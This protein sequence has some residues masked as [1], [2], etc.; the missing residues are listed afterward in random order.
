MIPRGQTPERRAYMKA[1]RESHPS[2]DRRAYKAAYDA[3]NRERIAEYRAKNKARLAAI[4]AEWYVANRASVLARVK[5]R[6]QEKRTEILAYQE[7][8][9]AANTAKVKANVR[10]YQAANPDKKIHLANRRRARQ[11]GN[12]G[13][14]TVAE[15]LAKFAALGNVC[16]YCRKP[17]RLTIDHDIPLARGGTDNIENILPACKSCNSKKNT[18][19]SVEFFAHQRSGGVGGDSAGSR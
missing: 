15:R 17:G 18:R 7:R 4:K 10:A 16:V 11:I 13:S 5:A 3:Q 12:G 1:Y 19:T 2:R 8:Y 14:H 6:S 9:Y